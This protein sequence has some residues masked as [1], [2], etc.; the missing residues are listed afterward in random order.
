MFRCER[1]PYSGMVLGAFDGVRTWQVNSFFTVDVVAQELVSAHE[2]R[3]LRLQ[4]GTPYGAALAVLGA[5]VR[6][7]EYPVAD[8]VA[9]TDACRTVHESYA[10]FMSVARVSGGL[11]TLTGNLPYLEY[12]RT[13]AAL[14]DAVGHDEL[15]LSTL[16][17]LFHQLMA[18][19]PDP[20]LQAATTLPHL[21][22]AVRLVEAE[23][24]NDRLDRLLA[25]VS[26][27]PVLVGRLVDAVQPRSVEENLDAVAEVLTAAGL[28]TLT[29]AEQDKLSQAVQDGFNSASGTHQI[30]LTRRSRATSLE[31]QLDYVANETIQLHQ[32]PLT[33]ELG[34]GSLPG[35][36]HPFTPF[37][38]DDTD[39]GPHLWTVLLTGQVLAHQFQTIIDDKEGIYFGFLGGDR[40]GNRPWRTEP[41]ALLLTVNESPHRVTAQL[42]ELGLRTLLMTTLSTFARVVHDVGF[43]DTEPLF[44]LVD[45]RIRPFL[46]GLEQGPRVRWATIALTGD[47]L[48]HTVVLTTDDDQPL[49]FVWVAT[50]YTLKPV[51][52]WLRRNETQFIYAGEDYPDVSAEL[53]GL[54]RHLV[55]TFST[56][57]SR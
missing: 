16:E 57:G 11:D 12:W 47:R 13:G 37:V 21:A 10:T 38:R 40:V 36:M 39:I 33:L 17:F 1:D 14:A 34:T 6:D 52:E 23:P 54:L 49:H 8:W 9:A 5:A 55:G 15:G 46:H 7:G 43:S 18:P 2:E 45:E 19:I 44:V 42:A 31:D 3:H 50:I 35:G 29:T 4:Q 30:T 22:A 32:H 24:P 48:L 41:G 28:P 26:D 53:F 51:L 25:M 20:Q 56:L 27:D